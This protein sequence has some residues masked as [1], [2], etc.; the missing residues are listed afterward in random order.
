MP[1]RRDRD[2]VLRFER[3]ERRLHWALAV[4]YMVCLASALTLILFYNFS[5]ERPHREVVS[6]IHR[7]GGVG[8]ILLPFLA[9]AGSPEELKIHFRNVRQA[10]GWTLA[11]LKWLAL[12]A[13]AVFRIRGRLPDQGKFNAG[14]KLN[15]MAV[16]ISYPLFI[17]TG[18][19]IWLPG[20]ALV[21]W[22]IHVLLGL[23]VAPVV[24][25]HVYMALLNRGTREGL[26]GMVTGYVDRDWAE[27]HYRN[28][29]RDRY[30]RDALPA[31]GAGHGSSEPAPTR[32]GAGM[33]QDGAT[34]ERGGG[35]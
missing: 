5:P 17:L 35:I 29:Y 30:G 8:L 15:F 9:L 1:D 20:I 19:L 12:F 2:T 28:W 23:A 10:W 16:M 25:G 4:P 3:S 21:P 11:D 24:A 13:G 32:L 18:V 26:A 33:H 27:E 14:E 6:W 31:K 7:G 22:L 34:P